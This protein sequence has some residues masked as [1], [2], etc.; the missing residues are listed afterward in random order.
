VRGAAG[1]SI[2]SEV[3]EEIELAAKVTG[4]V[5]AALADES[6]VLAVPRE[7]AE[8]AV[9]RIHYRHYPKLVQR[10]IRAAEKIKASG[11]PRHAYSALDDPLLTAILEG[12]AEEEEPSLQER[13]ENLIANALT[14]QSAIVRRAFPH[15]LRELD[16]RDAQVLQHYASETSDERVFVEKFTTMPG[17]RDGALLGNLSRL[18]L[19]APLRQQGNSSR[20]I[21]VGQ[22]NIVGY[23]FTE[24]GWAFVKACRAP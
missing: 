8:Y 15:I 17:E 23:V 11:L 20:S 19:L 22:D 18:G 3:G 9:S 2:I 4:D 14:E 6:G 10:A 13:W 5:V 21:L 24:L 1:H 12:A 16:P 7:Y